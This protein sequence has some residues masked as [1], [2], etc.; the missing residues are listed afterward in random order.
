MSADA[1]GEA[2]DIVGQAGAPGQIVGALGKL[3]QIQGL[4]GDLIDHGIGFFWDRRR[5][6]ALT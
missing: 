1:L 6:R 5:W 4:D 2:A 3:A